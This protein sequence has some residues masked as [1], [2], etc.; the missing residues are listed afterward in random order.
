M[1][2]V[3]CICAQKQLNHVTAP[4]PT[5]FLASMISTL[6][7]TDLNKYTANKPCCRWTNKVHYTMFTFSLPKAVMWESPSCLNSR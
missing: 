3:S 1:T 2:Q 4:I 6:Q 5:P 7:F